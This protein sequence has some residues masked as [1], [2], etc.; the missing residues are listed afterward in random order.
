MKKYDVV[1]IGS[2]AGESIARRAANK[3]LSVA[4]IDKGPIG[5]TCLNL[6]CIPSKL[7][8]AVA[9]RI[10]QIR[11]AAEFG[12]D[13]EIKNV[14]LNNVMAYMH[15]YVN[16]WHDGLV[17]SLKESNIDL[18][19]YESHF[20][21]EYK[22][23]VGNIENIQGKK[24]FIASGARPLIPKIKG[25]KNY[26]TNE[27]VL[28]IKSLPK[29]MVI[30]GGGYVAVEY[31]HFFEAM[32]TKITIM[33]RSNR[34][35][36]DEDQEISFLLEE[37]LK[38]RK[39][40]TIT[41]TEVVEIKSK[42]NGFEVIGKDKKNAY[43]AEAADKIFVATGRKS[44]ADLLRVYKSGI[45]TDERNYIKV[46]DYLQTNKENIWALGDAT[47]KQ[48]FTHSSR[49]QAEIAWHNATNKKKKKFDFT[50]VPH[51]IY[52]YPQIASIGL[53]EALARKK[54]KINIHK[55]SYND[56]TKGTA[57]RQDNTFL[58]AISKKDDGRLLGF[59][60]IG[61]HA[62]VLIQEVTNMISNDLT[63]DSIIE[64]MHIHPSLSETV[65]TT[66][67]KI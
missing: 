54:Y 45:E 41:D 39:I 28:Q 14:S 25:L 9:D 60:I 20:Y 63:V 67:S 15:K 36:P 52:S 38:K 30:I 58:K 21:D 3:N 51:G 65:Q 49:K 17:K 26:Y 46:N 8:M 59:H 32:G 24:I 6:A 31:A 56:T 48:M 34:L 53:T 23:H 18:Y 4:L 37:R 40:R 5:G 27:S 44:N 29:S 62:P 42:E 47:G 19:Q 11:S 10:M 64:T 16:K 12:I 66:L 7:L 55:A 43:I 57:L 33:Q 22:L 2:G 1:V 35:I 50:F 61:P 13:V